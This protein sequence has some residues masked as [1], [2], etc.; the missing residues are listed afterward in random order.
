MSRGIPLAAIVLVAGLS[1]PLMQ[2][3]ASPGEGGARP[4]ELRAF[5]FTEPAP[6]PEGGGHGVVPPRAAKSS[7]KGPEGGGHGVV[8]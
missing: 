8:G 4:S 2:Q 3:V 6:G 5:A 7:P 1:N